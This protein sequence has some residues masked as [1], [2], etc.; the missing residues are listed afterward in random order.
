MME[1]YAIYRLKQLKESVLERRFLKIEEDD[2]IDEGVTRRME[3][4]SRRIFTE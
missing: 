2:N 3:M 1:C 4:K